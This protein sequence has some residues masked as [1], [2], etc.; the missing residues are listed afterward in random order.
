MNQTLLDSH[1]FTKGLRMISN[2]PLQLAWRGLSVAVLSLSLS[3]CFNLT[4]VH[5]TSENTARAKA[6]AV[7]AEVRQALAPS[8]VLRVGVYPGSPTSWVK[9]PKTGESVGIALDLGKGMAK[10]LNV[11][12]Q[13]VEFD[14]VAQ[15][16]EALKDGKVDMTF[17]NATAVR[18]K[19]MDFTDPLVRLELG[20]LVIGSSPL[21]SLNDIDQAGKRIG[22]SQGSSSQGV[23]TQR[24]KLAKVVPAESLAQAQT[25]LNTQ[26]I[27]AF[28]TNKGILFEMSDALPGSRVLTGRWGLE[29]LAIAIPKDR[30]AGRSF[31]DKF[32]KEVSLS[33]ELD[34]AVQRSGLRGTARD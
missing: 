24:F 20:Y 9:D 30:E 22:V 3:A 12:V 17:T 6:E 4:V 31:V 26:Q 7:T 33:G 15:V 19:D 32:S 28:A 5:Q 23:L 13:V 16:L 27:D 10:R 18:A 29:N 14:R 25:L 34:K 8:G 2:H 1:S 11:P 21:T